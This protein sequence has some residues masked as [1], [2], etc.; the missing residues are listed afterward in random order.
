[1]GHRFWVPLQEASNA[2]QAH[3]R[4]LRSELHANNVACAPHGGARDRGW[5]KGHGGERAPPPRGKEPQARPARRWRHPPSAAPP[6]GQATPAPPTPT[7]LR[8]PWPDGSPTGGPTGKLPRRQA[9]PRRH[10]LT[11]PKRQHKDMNQ[12]SMEAAACMASARQWKPAL[13]PVQGGQRH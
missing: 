13:L 7:T 10:H 5:A 6:T 1:M 9:A 8:T 3:A 12:S 2:R 4:Q 11:A